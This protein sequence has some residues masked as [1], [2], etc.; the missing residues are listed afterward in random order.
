MLKALIEL[1]YNAS[2]GRSIS[3]ANAFRNGY[4]AAIQSRLKAMAED[5][6]RADQE[7]ATKSN[8]R[9]LVAIDQRTA[10]M[11]KL[12]GEIG[13]NRTSNASRSNEGYEAG[14]SAHIPTNHPVSQASTQLYLK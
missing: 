5:R 10:I 13:R 3:E 11:D 4:G 9:N 6:D 14:K 8:G 7:L 1:A 2:K 12:W